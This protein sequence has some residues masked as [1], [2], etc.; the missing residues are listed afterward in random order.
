MALEIINK[1]KFK[2][3]KLGYV[4]LSD[5]SVA[6]LRA[7]VTA[8]RIHEEASPF[9]V[10]FEVDV[11]VGISLYPSEKSMEE[12]KDKPILEP[13]KTVNEGWTSIDII[14]K[15]PAYE[16][17]VYNDGKV[18]LYLIRVEIEPFMASKNTMFKTDRNQPLYV[19]RWVP[20]VTWR[21]LEEGKT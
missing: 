16:E 13:G 9:G 7:A 5:G 6:L 14:D 19:V 3:S 2:E 12:I 10:E 21:K 4:R 1:F 8:V 11:T 17:L 18:G 15:M 20:K